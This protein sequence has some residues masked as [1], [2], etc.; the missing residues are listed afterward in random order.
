M[1]GTWCTCTRRL[2]NFVTAGARDGI[3]AEHVNESR[4]RNYRIL[5]LRHGITVPLPYALCSLEATMP[6]CNGAKSWPC[7]LH[8]KNFATVPS[9]STHVVCIYTFAN[10]VSTYALDG[11]FLAIKR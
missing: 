9:T 11:S 5:L 10:W 6:S 7:S 4:T 3:G 1:C 8:C 2:S